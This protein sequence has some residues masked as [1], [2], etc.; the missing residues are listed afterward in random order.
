MTGAGD[1]LV[2]AVLHGLGDAR[3]RLRALAQWVIEASRPPRGV[4]LVAPDGAEFSGVLL[5]DRNEPVM[6]L[7]VCVPR[8]RPRSTNAACSDRIDTPPSD[9]DMFP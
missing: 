4:Y 1:A 7:A 2:D 3:P 6:M 8:L 9:D 5:V